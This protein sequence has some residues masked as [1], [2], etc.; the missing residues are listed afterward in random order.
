MSGIDYHDRLFRS[1][2]NSSSGV[3]RSDTVF[4]YRQEGS[5]GAHLW[6]ATALK[7]V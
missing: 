7:N 5:V 1:T 4:H 6:S 2:A 3:V